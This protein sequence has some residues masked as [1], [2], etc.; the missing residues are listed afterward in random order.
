VPAP[1][2]DLKLI[3][4]AVVEFRPKLSNWLSWSVD[5]DDIEITPLRVWTDEGDR[6]RM[7]VGA[8]QVLDYRPKVTAENEVVVPDRQRAAAEGAI[9]VAV[10]LIAVSQ[11]SRRGI[12]SPWPPAVFQA[13]DDDG[14]S[15]LDERVGVKHDRL[16][17]RLLIS[18]SLDL[19]ES[20]LNELLDRLDGVKLL[21][22][23]LA[24]DHATGRYH[25]LVRLFE[26]AFKLS[27][28]K[29]SEPVAAFLDTRF[30]YTLDEVREWFETH[31][32][33]ATHADQRND[34]SVEADLRPVVDRMEQ[35]ALDVLFNKENWRDDTTDRRSLWTPRAGT[36]GPE[37]MV[38]VTQGDSPPPQTAQLMDEFGVFPMNLEAAIKDKPEEWWPRKHPNAS[39][40]EP[41]QVRVIEAAE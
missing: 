2:K 16:K 36:D 18:Q 8:S 30:G 13:T 39:K 19:D 32:D 7:L 28:P 29:L 11:G 5:Q 1:P 27:P 40:T 23:V 41:F 35:A 33:P 22:E 20:A 38:F 12:S 3:R 21:N 9:E 4:L 10:E 24:H 15:W 17:Q 37:G 34:F 14:R 26:R 6:T 25:D 31:R